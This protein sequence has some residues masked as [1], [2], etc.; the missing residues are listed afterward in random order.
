MFVLK[1]FLQPE[2]KVQCQREPNEANEKKIKTVQNFMQPH[3]NMKYLYTTNKLQ[4]K[5]NKTN[6]ILNK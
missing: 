4:T 1:I 6:T 2:L 3:R 5:F